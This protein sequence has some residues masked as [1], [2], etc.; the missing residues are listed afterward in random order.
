MKLEPK[1]YKLA[2]DS[3]LN[4]MVITDVEGKIMY[5]NKAA[6]AMTGYSNAEIVGS[7]PRLWGGR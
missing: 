3:A 1:I 4:H 7:N 6:S 2:V 5:A